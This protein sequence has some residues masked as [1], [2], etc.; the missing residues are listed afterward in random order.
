[1]FRR[2]HGVDGNRAR[3]DRSR[4]R[5]ACPGD[6]KTCTGRDVLQLDFALSVTRCQAGHAPDRVP[7]ATGNAT[8]ISDPLDAGSNV[9]AVAHQIIALHNDVMTWMPMRSGSS[10]LR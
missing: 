9:Y 1:M 4:R 5:S 10:R 2:Q 7:G 3:G 8:G 6:A